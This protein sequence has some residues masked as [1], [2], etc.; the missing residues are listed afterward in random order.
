MSEPTKYDYID[1]VRGLAILAVVFVHSGSI[2]HGLPPFLESAY[3][4]GNLGV[5]LFFVASALTLCLSMSN[6][7]EEDWYNFYIRRFFRIAPIFYCGM[8]FYFFWHLLINYHATGTIALSEGD[9]LV[10][11]VQ[12]VLFIHGFSPSNFNYLVPGAWSI[13]AEV[14]FYALFP[15]IFAVVRKGIVPLLTLFI[16]TWAV[17]IIGQI[18][19]FNFV[20]PRLIAEGLIS[21]PLKNDSFSFI[22]AN[23]FNQLPVFLAGCTAFLLIKSKLDWRHLVVAFLLCLTS[24]LLQVSAFIHTN[25]NGALYATLSA[26]GFAIGVVWLANQ[27]IVHNNM[28][29]WL[30]R[31]GK[32][33]FAIYI[34]HFAIISL[35]HLAVEKLQLEQRFSSTAL[36]AVLFVVATLSSTK[37]AEV[38]HFWIEQPGI[39]LGKKVIAH[40]AKRKSPQPDAPKALQPPATV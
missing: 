35:L 2:L 23:I 34:G 7:S 17:S 27:P 8:V 3:A 40:R 11:L 13:G 37:I 26:M 9:T 25:F 32:L 39:A 14:A 30:I 38:I 24:Q 19:L 20:S 28:T 16:V 29:R 33:S 36:L 1:I 18:V 15:F 10:A 22:Y 4:Y 5:Q 6:R 21:E 31:I 12:N